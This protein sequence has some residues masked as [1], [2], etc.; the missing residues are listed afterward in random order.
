MRKKTLKYE[1]TKE[2]MVPNLKTTQ[3]AIKRKDYRKW[4]TLKEEKT[5]K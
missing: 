1:F 3:G 4:E 5:R 2:L